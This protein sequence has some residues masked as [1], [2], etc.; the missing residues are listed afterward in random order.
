MARE[1]T[2]GFGWGV[3]ALIGML[4]EKRKEGEKAGA[5]RIQRACGGGRRARGRRKEGGEK[6]ADRWG[7]SVGAAVKRKREG[8]GESGGP[9]GELGWAAWAERVQCWLCFFF[10]LHF[11]ILFQ[12]KF[13]S[14]FFK[15][16]SRIL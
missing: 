15:L 8:E 11:Q 10:K 9:A 14:N 16:F 4:T 3:I 13:K 12:L 6:G 2:V 7:P 5:R 1:T